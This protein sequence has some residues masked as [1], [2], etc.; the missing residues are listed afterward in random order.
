M[1]VTDILYFQ[2][3]EY[4][5]SAGYLATF[6]SRSV[7]VNKKGQIPEQLLEKTINSIV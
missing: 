3:S 2:E 7:R 5:I 6:F 1:A 4:D